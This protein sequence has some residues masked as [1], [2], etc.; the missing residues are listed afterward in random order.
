MT[1]RDGDTFIGSAKFS[2]PGGGPGRGGSG[3]RVRGEGPGAKTDIF[4]S[5]KRVYTV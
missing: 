1:T 3:G 2:R 5:M 4:V